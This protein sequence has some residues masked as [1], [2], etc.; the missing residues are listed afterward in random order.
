MQK[1]YGRHIFANFVR[2]NTLNNNKLQNSDM[3]FA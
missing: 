2:F 3:E 1:L